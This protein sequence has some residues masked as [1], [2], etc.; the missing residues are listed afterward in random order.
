[1][2]EFAI[3]YWA[4]LVAAV[5]SMVVG[6]VWYSPAVF[7]RTWMKLSS[8]SPEKMEAAK[9]KGMA[10]SYFIAFIGSL[11]MAYI[12]AYFLV[13]GAAFSVSESMALAFWLWLGFVVILKLGDVLWAGDPVT[14]FILN[15]AHYFVAIEVMAIIL[16]VWS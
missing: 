1:M 4:V 3:N 12:L 13:L 5:T 15:I 8:M 11:V 9:K 7:G 10:R 6:A 16:T 2:T 14:L